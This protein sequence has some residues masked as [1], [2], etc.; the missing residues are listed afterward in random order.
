MSADLTS[1][2]K[3]TQLRAL[4][5][6]RKVAAYFISGS[7]AFGNEYPPPHYLRIK[8]LTGF[9]GSFGHVLLTAQQAS[10]ITDGRYTLQAKQQ[11]DL[12]LYQIIVLNAEPIDE[13]NVRTFAKQE[14]MWR[15]LMSQN[16]KVRQI[17]F[18][19]MT[20]SYTESER[21]DGVL[22]DFNCKTTYRP[23]SLVDEIWVDRPALR[24]N[25]VKEYP[26]KFSGQSVAEKIAAVQKQL[27]THK[28]DA[29]LLEHA[30][31]IAWL[32]NVRGTDVAYNTGVLSHLIIPAKGRAQW[33][34]DAHRVPPTLQKNLQKLVQILPPEKARAVSDKIK[35][36]VLIDG[37][38]LRQLMAHQCKRIKDL[39]L[40]RRMRHI[41]NPTEIDAIRAVMHQDGRAWQAAMANIKKAAGK[42][43]ELTIDQTLIAA[44]QKFANYLCESFG[45]IVGVG[46]NGAIIHYRANKT[47]NR[48]WHQNQPLLLDSGAHYVGGTTDATRVLWG[49][50][51][52]TAE[53]KKWYTLVLKG[54]IALSRAVFPAGT[55]GAQLDIIARQHL[56]QAGYSYPHGTGH[57]VGACAGVHEP[58]LTISPRGTTTS[59]QAGMIF[60]NEP[61][62]YASGQFGIRIENLGVISPLPQRSSSSS[63][64]PRLIDLLPPLAP[65]KKQ[66]SSTTWLCFDTLTA[67]PLESKLID[68]TLLT[69]D[70]RAWVDTYHRWVKRVTGSLPA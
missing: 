31:D 49:L 65:T 60:S 51:T 56:W 67:I 30:D 46:S 12:D 37:D 4:M 47:T 57:G 38:H 5:K 40:V 33:F 11:V 35:G 20:T 34:I 26:D 22:H 63:K 2:Q 21:L 23:E 54:M 45:A 27:Q 39:P 69:P 44:R 66:S 64:T 42:I 3:L 8:W 32:L 53:H 9:S 52:P 25:T 7:D 1:K 15:W 28:A 48:V 59:V 16:P 70:E 41:K 61:G 14:D 62:Y 10:L 43:D 55:T 18:D 17:D 58:P 36:L 6:K 68:Q 19:G 50:G 24:L 13:P 29:H